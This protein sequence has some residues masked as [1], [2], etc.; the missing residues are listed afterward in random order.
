MTTTCDNADGDFS[1]PGCGGADADGKFKYDSKGG[2]QMMELCSDCANQIYKNTT[3][4]E[5]ISLKRAYN[6]RELLPS[7]YA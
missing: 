2:G 1:S 3:E 5:R 6:R 7:F 4:R